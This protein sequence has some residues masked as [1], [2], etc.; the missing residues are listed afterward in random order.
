MAVKMARE[1]A[2]RS[3]HVPG[4]FPITGAQVLTNF[5]AGLMKRCNRGL[6]LCSDQKYADLQHDARI[7]KD[8]ERRIRWSGRNLLRDRKM[9]KRFPQIHNP[10]QSE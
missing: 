3:F 4:D 5:Q 10:P 1:D 8:S 2:S 9:I 6:N 7:I